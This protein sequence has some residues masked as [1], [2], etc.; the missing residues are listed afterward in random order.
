MKQRFKSFHLCNG[1]DAATESDQVLD[2]FE[3]ETPAF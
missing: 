2:A 1:S 3:M